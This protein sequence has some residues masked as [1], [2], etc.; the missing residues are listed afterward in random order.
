MVIFL[1]CFTRSAYAKEVDFNIEKY[2]SNESSNVYSTEMFDIYNNVETL[3]EN[4]LDDTL[5]NIGDKFLVFYSL[6]PKTSDEVCVD[7]QGKNIVV[8]FKTNI[9]NKF[10]YKSNNENSLIVMSECNSYF[11]E[12]AE[13]LYQ[14]KIELYSLPS[15][16]VETSAFVPY[17]MA[18][19]RFSNYDGYVDVQYEVNM[20]KDVTSVSDLV[21]VN[22]D[23]DFVCGAMAKEANPNANYYKRK[24][25]GAGSTSF[26]KVF[27]EPAYETEPDEKEYLIYGGEHVVKDFW[28]LSS[29]ESI[30]LTSSFESS[31]NIGYSSKNGL[32]INSQIVT[33]YSKTYTTS[34][35]GLSVQKNYNH[36]RGV[37]WIY[38]YYVATQTTFNARNGYLFEKK[39]WRN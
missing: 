15:V 21:L 1:M 38:I 13:E 30:T 6:E 26:V 12:K 2:L 11:M 17:Y 37:E 24:M 19:E 28:P 5:S 7:L 20:L 35:P 23:V 25:H 39:T 14:E 16:L 4:D 29:P 9:L 27:T 8:F 3:S 34:N 10:S 31:T 22:C 36:V 32:S 33:S 18:Q